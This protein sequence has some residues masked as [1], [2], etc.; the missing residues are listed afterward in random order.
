MHNRERLSSSQLVER[1]TYCR[2]AESTHCATLHSAVVVLQTS[3]K[4]A[5]AK[6]VE[7]Y[8]VPE[9][10]D[11][12]RNPGPPYACPVVPAENEKVAPP[13][14]CVCARA[15]GARGRSSGRRHIFE[16]ES[17]DVE[18]EGLAHGASQESCLCVGAVVWDDAADCENGQHPIN[19][20]GCQAHIPLVECHRKNYR[21]IQCTFSV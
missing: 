5:L 17:H 3:I 13:P 7:K 21:V 12:M 20:E 15:F 14:S 18:C 8:S 10:D 11:R 9:G 2:Q 6:Y 19:I 4:D 16:S 1:F